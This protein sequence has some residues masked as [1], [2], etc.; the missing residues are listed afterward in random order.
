MVRRGTNETIGDQ[1]VEGEEQSASGKRNLDTVCRS[2]FSLSDRQ[3][4]HCDER[5]ILAVI[6]L[7]SVRTA[8]HVPRHSGHIAHLANRQPF[9]RSR[10]YQRRSNEPNDHKDREQ[11]TDESAKIH[12]PSSHRM[13]TLGRLI[14][15]HVR[16]PAIGAPKPTQTHRVNLKPKRLSR[17]FPRQRSA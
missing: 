8:R 3:H 5:A 16:Q 14:T 15:S 6:V 9:C 17:H 11:T 12:D 1:I 4:A 10:C 13:E 7:L 2:R